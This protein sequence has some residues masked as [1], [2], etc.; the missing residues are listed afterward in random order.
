MKKI[1]FAFTI[2]VSGIILFAG[3]YKSAKSVSGFVKGNPEI[4]SI[5]ALTFGPKG[6]LFIGDSKSAS[7][8]AI[9]TKDNKALKSASAI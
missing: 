4:K 3:T 2:I 5:S 1:I 8:F 9:D 6:V 7:V